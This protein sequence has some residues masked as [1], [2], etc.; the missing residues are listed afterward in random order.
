MLLPEKHIRLAESLF[1]LGGI[2]LAWLDD[3]IVPDELWRICQIHSGTAVLPTHPTF[4]TFVLAVNFLYSVGVVDMD[5]EG[6]L[7]RATTSA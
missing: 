1:G 6:R 5:S 4:D 3:P 2:L 7:I